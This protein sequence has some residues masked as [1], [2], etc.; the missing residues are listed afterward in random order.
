MQHGT[1]IAGERLRQIAHDLAGIQD[2]LRV[3][4]V[5]DLAEDVGQRPCRLAQKPAAAEPVPVLAAD[6]PVRG[7]YF[8]VQ[9]RRQLL[10]AVDVVL[11][12]QVQ[13][14][15]Q[16]QLAVACVREQ[17][18]RDLVLLEHILQPRQEI[19][20]RLGRH[21]D[22]LRKRQRPFGPSQPEERRDHMPRQS[23]EKLHVVRFQGQPRL[24]GQPLATADVVGDLLQPVPQ[25]RGLVPLLLH[26]Q[27][28]LGRWRQ[29]HVVPHIQLASQAEQ[30]SIHQ[31]ARSG[32]HATDLQRSMRCILQPVKQQQDQTHVLGQG[33]GAHGRFGDQAQR[34]LGTDQQLGQIELPARKYLAQAIAATTDHRWRLMLGDRRCLALQ[35]R[36]QSL[37]E[38]LAERPWRSSAAACTSW[39]PASIV[40]PLASTTCRLS[41]CWRAEPYF[42]Q[43]LP[44]ASTA[45]TP[46]MV[47]TLAVAGSG[48]NNRFLSARCRF[49]WPSTT[50]G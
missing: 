48:P 29:Q 32:P 22:I 2:V 30:P 40:W 43:W 15:A 4:D 18:G 23:P 50:P 13:K 46:P 9:I 16:V 38:R 33:A 21:A 8:L 5:L 44:D 36:G 10:H 34:A 26:Q 24:K 11:F 12:G 19:R 39:R 17:R 25:F 27:Q 1:Q 41:T 31:V 14:R 6:R 37:H 35:Q 7:Q 28:G 42:I 3:E 47:D 20:Q 45:R 49:R